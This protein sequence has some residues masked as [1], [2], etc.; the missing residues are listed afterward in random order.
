M[1]SFTENEIKVINFL[2]RNFTERYSINQISKKLRISPM[3]CY[4]ILKKL[5]TKEVVKYEK[6]GNAQFYFVDL[7]TP[8]SV[9]IAE[10]ALTGE[11]NDPITEVFRDDIAPLKEIT[12]AV[13]VFGSFAENPKNANDIDLL[14][15]LE[16]ANYKK[17]RVEIDK[18]NKISPKEIH[19][20]FQTEEDFKKN[21]KEKD[22]VVLNI[23]SKGYILWGSEYIVKGLIT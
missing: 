21:I 22:K 5:E 19:P 23:L 4:K 15:L 13:M 20:L 17:I 9:K 10:L 11:K 2:I 1:A 12:K 14:I 8:F 16:N 3:G 18:L 7:K 6:I